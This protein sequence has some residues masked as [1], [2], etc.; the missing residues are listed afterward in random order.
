MG[1]KEVVFN[2]KDF[3]PIIRYIEENE[4][5]PEKGGIYIGYNPRNEDIYRITYIGETKNLKRGIKQCP[6][7]CTHYSYKLISDQTKRRDLKKELIEVFAPEGNKL[8]DN[9]RSWGEEWIIK[10]KDDSINLLRRPD[11]MLKEGDPNWF[12]KERIENIS[13]S[14]INGADISSKKV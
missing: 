5:V 4:K 7:G 8:A 3:N 12:E 11:S 10:K 6:K 14:S 1:E 13:I 9:S 2:K